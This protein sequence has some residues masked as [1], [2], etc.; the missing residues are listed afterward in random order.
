M[1]GEFSNGYLH[2]GK[3]ENRID[4]QFMDLRSLKLKIKV[5]RILRELLTFISCRKPTEAE[6]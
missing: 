2:D 4:A 3:E 6:I 5:L 1:A